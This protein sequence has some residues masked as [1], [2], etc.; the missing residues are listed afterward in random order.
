[1]RYINLIF[2]GISCIA[3]ACGA[4]SVESRPTEPAKTI[5]RGPIGEA[6]Q[7]VR[8]VYDDAL[9]NNCASIPENLTQEFRDAVGSSQDGLQALCDTF[10]DSKKVTAVD[11]V[12]ENISGDSARVQVALKH[13]NGKIEERE[14]VVKK[15]QGRWVMDS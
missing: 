4:H 15:L 10:T 5:Q 12:G 14:E 13:R 9:N 11:V 8:K 7:I 6:S 1:M 2:V 3:A